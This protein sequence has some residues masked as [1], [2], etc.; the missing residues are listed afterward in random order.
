[1][2][3]DHRPKFKLVHDP[4]GA[5]FAAALRLAHALPRFRRRPDMGVSQ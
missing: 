5:S 2:P 4:E 1:M 3:V